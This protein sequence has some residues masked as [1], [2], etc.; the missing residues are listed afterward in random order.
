MLNSSE[1]IEQID[2]Y[3]VIMHEECSQ[4]GDILIIRFQNGFGVKILR[5]ALESK[6]PSFFVV[7]VLKFQGPKIKDF[8]LA[9]YSSVPE[10]NWLDGQEEIARLCQEVSCLPL[11]PKD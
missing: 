6:P 8:K 4:E 2:P 5:L 9:Q 3:I 10:V 11:N 1:L 7:M